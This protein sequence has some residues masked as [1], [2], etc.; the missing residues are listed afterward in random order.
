MA[1]SEIPQNEEN[2]RDEW[3]EEDG[4]TQKDSV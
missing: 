1:T 2:I 3:E 4:I